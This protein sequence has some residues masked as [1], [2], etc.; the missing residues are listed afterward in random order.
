MTPEEADIARDERKNGRRG[1]GRNT[2][3]SDSTVQQSNN[4][5]P[6]EVEVLRDQ[7]KEKMSGQHSPDKFNYV[8]TIHYGNGQTDKFLR[9]QKTSSDYGGFGST[10]SPPKPFKPNAYGSSWEA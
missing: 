10:P 8:E 1:G 2:L 6:E 3:P 9:F 4:L 7:E 5:T